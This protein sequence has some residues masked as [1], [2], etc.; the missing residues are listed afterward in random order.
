MQ[1][2][3]KPKSQTEKCEVSG[4]LDAGSLYDL[5]TAIFLWQ[6]LLT[7]CQKRESLFSGL[8]E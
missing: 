7:C 6:F 1:E 3:G 2:E 4:F 8:V 5:P